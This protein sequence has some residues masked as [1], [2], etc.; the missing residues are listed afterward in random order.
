MSPRPPAGVRAVGRVSFRKLLRIGR[1]GDRILARL[2]ACLAAQAKSR[3][4]QQSRGIS[5]E[6]AQSGFQGRIGF[7]FDLRSIKLLEFI[8][9]QDI[10]SHRVGAVPLIIAFE[11]NLLP[12]ETR[13][14]H[15]VVS[16]KPGIAGDR[17]TTVAYEAEGSGVIRSLREVTTAYGVLDRGLE[18]MRL[19]VVLCALRIGNIGLPIAPRLVCPCT[20]RHRKGKRDY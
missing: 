15:A 11:V 13:A 2:L 3:K 7:T 9:R 16:W 17:V 12:N 18:V 19:A 1:I 14:Y 6:Q 5:D 8:Q 10:V 20:Y 4:V